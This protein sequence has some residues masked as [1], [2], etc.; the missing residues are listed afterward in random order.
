MF[1]ED[2]VLLL[3]Q[4][5]KMNSWDS[6]LMNSFYDQIIKGNA[7]TEKQAK[8]IEGILK[9]QVKKL[10]EVTGKDFS[11]YVSNPTYKNPLRI[12][13]TTRKISIASDPVFGKLFKVE[14]PYNEEILSKIRNDRSELTYA[15]W[16]KDTKS[17]LFSIN[18]KSIGLLTS[19]KDLY[20][21]DADD[22][23]MKYS[24]QLTDIIENA[25]KYAPML[26]KKDNVFQLA[27]VSEHTPS[28]HTENLLEALFSARKF[29]I[30]IWDPQIENKILSSSLNGTTVKFLKSAPGE[31]FSIN[32]EDHGLQSLEDII[33]YM[34]PVLFVI[35]GGTE[36]E[37]VSKSVDFLNSIGIANDQISVLFRVLTDKGAEFNNFVRSNRLNSP[38]TNNTRAVFVSSK[39]RKS[40]IESKIYFNCIVNFNFYDIHYQLRDYVRWHHDV[41]HI[42]A[43]KTQ[44]ESDFA[45]M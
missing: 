28:L 34:S 5:V 33:K 42:L 35:P 37:K 29:G 39:I 14:F 2:I 16:D 9:R 40:I 12:S 15:K 32:L 25:E 21:F 17:W 19:L 30:N 20:A 31:N 10:N 6:K 36:L 23:F 26:I 7:F 44:K 13:N 3:V 45:F 8:V 41:I 43:K 24:N 11:N 27:N 22:E 1:I 38:L 18:E 4:T